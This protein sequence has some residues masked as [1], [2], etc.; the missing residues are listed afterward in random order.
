M[1]QW[2]ISCQWYISLDDGEHEFGTFL[3]LVS[4]LS[5]NEAT[6]KLKNM[7]PQH[8]LSDFENHTIE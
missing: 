4:A 5:Y 3:K 1:K 6:I 7:F 8:I 2:L